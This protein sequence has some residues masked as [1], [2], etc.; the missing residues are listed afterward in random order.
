MDGKKAVITGGNSGIGRGIARSLALLGADI[1]FVGRHR[2]SIEETEKELA[3]LGVKAKGCVVDISAREEANRFFD[4]YYAENGLKLDILVANA[5]V[6]HDKRLLD[7]TE[8]EADKMYQVNMKGTLFFLQ[9]AS[10]AMKAQK[11][12][13]IV[14]ITS[15]NG[16]RPNPPQAFY[17]ATKAAQIAMMECLAC[18]LRKFNVRVNC[19]APGAVWTN[20]G[21]NGEGR[22]SVELPA[23][24]PNSQALDRVGLPEDIGDACACIVSD[25]FRYMTGTTVAVDGGI[26]LRL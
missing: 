14:I 24:S 11:S 23:E 20:I 7:A 22:H 13:N 17:S 26:L 3:A 25:A 9:R 21:Q 8:E 2:K 1:T 6:E 18:D 15:V 12:G 16:L 10:E 5:S 19:I 4:E